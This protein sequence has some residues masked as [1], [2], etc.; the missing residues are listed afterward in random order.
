MG[1][2][3]PAPWL[4][5]GHRDALAARFTGAANKAVSDALKLQQA[6]EDAL[7]KANALPAGAP[8]RE[9]VISKA[10]DVINSAKEAVKRAAA[11]ELL[12]P[13]LDTAQDYVQ[14]SLDLQISKAG[15]LLAFNGL[16]LAV[17]TIL[18]TQKE[19]LEARYDT[20]LFWLVGISS[21][22]TLL[23]ILVW[24][25][26]PGRFETADADLTS[27][28]RVAAARAW[29]LNIAVVLAIISVIV[30]GLWISS[31]T[32]KAATPLLLQQPVSVTLTESKLAPLHLACNWKEPPAAKGQRD[33][34]GT[35]ECR[36]VAP[37]TK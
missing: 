7:S 19:S 35:M 24:W 14:R 23:L 15:G 10:T 11:H 37:K 3:P 12:S 17:G 21:V 18:W 25:S 32:D 4:I 20:G 16:V 30:L 6:A 22:L 2:F 34:Q 31:S 8:D 1:P 13:D 27:S 28:L 33:R 5:Q 26:K 29:V 9:T 36:S